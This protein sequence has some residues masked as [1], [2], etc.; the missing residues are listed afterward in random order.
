MGIHLNAQ[1]DENS[2][3]IKGVEEIR[4]IVTRRAVS[5]LK[6]HNIFY[7]FSR[8]CYKERKILKLLHQ[9]TTSVIKRRKEELLRNK[10]P[11]SSSDETGRKRRSPFL[12]NL[13]QGTIN[14]VPLSDDD[15]REQV[16]TFMFEVIFWFLFLFSYLFLFYFTGTRYYF[17]R[18]MLY[19]VPSFSTCRNSGVKCKNFRENKNNVYF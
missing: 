2:E 19:F 8:D 3:Y 18:D 15:I 9:T 4:Q 14:G 5:P 12:D 6:V 11:V 13:I 16:D 1:M 7:Y 10:N 17:F